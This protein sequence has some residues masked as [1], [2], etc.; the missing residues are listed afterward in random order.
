MCSHGLPAAGSTSRN[1]SGKKTGQGQGHYPVRRSD[2]EWCSVDTQASTWWVDGDDDVVVT[3]AEK[4]TW[5]D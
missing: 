2:R 1:S 4:N 3:V 5:K